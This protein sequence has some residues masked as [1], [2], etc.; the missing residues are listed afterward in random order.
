MYIL[1]HPGMGLMMPVCLA[2]E[3]L[4]RAVSNYGAT[5]AQ[6]AGL[7]DRNDYSV[8]A[9]PLPEASVFH[10]YTVRWL[11][12]PP[13]GPMDNCQYPASHSLK[14]T[15]CNSPGASEVKS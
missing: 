2:Y 9:G 12:P 4:S 6:G 7:A 10:T 13:R 3:S 14:G 15:A 8:H 11:G 1:D 5:T